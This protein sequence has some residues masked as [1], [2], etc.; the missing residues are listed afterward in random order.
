MATIDKAIQAILTDAGLG[1]DAVWMHK[2]SGKYI[3]YHWACEKAA[4]KKGIEWQPPQV[5]QA[6][7]KDKLAVILVTG[8]LGDKTEWSF[9][10]AAPYNT[11]QTYPFAMA[12]KRAKDRVIL[13]LIGLHGEVYSE[14]EADSFKEPA[15]A[16]APK[17]D[18][19]RLDAEAWVAG[20]TF[21]VQQLTTFPELHEWWNKNFTTIKAL[22]ADLKAKITAV[23]DAKK[24][25]LQKDAA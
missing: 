4:A 5:I 25:Q 18:N 20:A 16:P 6:C 11:T 10:E 23:K 1:S 22:P 8:K 24:T 7:A 21:D 3:M 14:E 19:A 15:P 2:Q 17:E 9:G 13:K 12:E